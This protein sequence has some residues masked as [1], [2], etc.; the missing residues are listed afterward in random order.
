MFFAAMRAALVALFLPYLAGVAVAQ[1]DAESYP[2]QPIKL[3]VPFAAG[4]GNDIIARVVAQKLSERFGQPVL[5]ENRTGGAGFVAVNVLLAAP[6]D[7]YTL[8]VAP[9]SVMVFNSALYAKMPYDPVTSFAPITR[10]AAFPFY[11]AISSSLPVKSVA[12]LVAWAK[13]NPAKANYGGTSGVFQLVT[14]QFKQKTG[15]PFEYVPFKSTAEVAAAVLNGQVTMALIDPPPLLAH[16]KSGK[17]RL[18]AISTMKR[19]TDFPDIPTLNEAGAQGVSV[20]GFSGIVAKAGTPSVIVK[21][22]EREVNTVIGLPDVLERFKQLS[23]YGVGGSSEEF[24]AD[25]AKQIPIWKEVAQKAN[26]KA[27]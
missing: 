14:E 13:A 26:L 19:S 5:T 12:E 8:L 22:L 17:I 3:L 11:L 24:A 21:K 23:V 1:D 15:A 20:E 10:M 4:G 25:V 18:L 9:N 6:A 27:E 2:K 16:L 7:G